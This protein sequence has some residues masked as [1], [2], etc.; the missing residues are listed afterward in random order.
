MSIDGQRMSAPWQLVSSSADS[1]ADI[2][3]TYEDAANNGEF[4]PPLVTGVIGEILWNVRDQK[5]DIEGSGSQA[6]SR[7]SSRPPRESLPHR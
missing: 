5:I 2:I 3:Q 7:S 6:V 4:K 1:M